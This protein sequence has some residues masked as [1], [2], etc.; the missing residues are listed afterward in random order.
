MG[1]KYEGFTGQIV[2]FSSWW[3][4]FAQ[5]FLTVLHNMS[6]MKGWHLRPYHSQLIS[7]NSMRR[8]THSALLWTSKALKLLKINIMVIS[9]NFLQSLSWLSIY[10]RVNYFKLIHLFKV[11]H[12]LGPRYLRKDIVSISDTHSHRGSIS[13]F[14]FKVFLKLSFFVCFFMRKT[15]EFSSA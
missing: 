3:K 2:I 5:C 14:H 1:A 10:D 8:S 11:K 9:P 13:D 7:M 6:C 12:G 15:M 4:N